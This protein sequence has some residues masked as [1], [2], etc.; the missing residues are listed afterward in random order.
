MHQNG[1]TLSDLP[2][3]DTQAADTFDGT[4]CVG[5]MIPRWVAE[6]VLR[7][8]LP[9]VP[10]LK[11]AFI[12]YPAEARSSMCIN[13][14]VWLGSTQVAYMR[15]DAPVIAMSSVE[16]PNRMCSPAC[17]NDVVCSIEPHQVCG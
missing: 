13:N 8:R 12:L 14:A 11:C 1:C 9:H 17:I 6:A 10:Q 4:E 3:L 16:V 15:N 5:Q 2:E 7:A